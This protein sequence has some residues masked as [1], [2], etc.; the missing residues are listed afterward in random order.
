MKDSFIAKIL[1]EDLTEYFTN[2]LEEIRIRKNKPVIFL[3]PEREIIT[4]KIFYRND[5][6]EFLEKITQSS[7]YSYYDDIANGFITV[8]GGHRVGLCGDAVYENEKLKSLRDITGI[9]IRIAKEMKGIGEGVFSKITSNKSIGNTL[10]IAPPGIGKTT[11][12]RDIT[13]LI[14]DNIEKT[15]LA[16]IDERNEISA[17]FMGNT[18]ND[19]GLRTDVFCGY[20]KYDGIMRALRSMSPNVIVVDEIGSKEDV[21]AIKK[22]FYSGVKIIASVH[23]ENIDDVFGNL[24]S[25]IKENV[26]DFFVTLKKDGT[27]ERK[28]IIDSSTDV[29][30]K[31]GRE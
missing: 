7:I 26:F 5:I 27:Y 1:P 14:S 24:S 11:L 23:G 4:K 2:T 19:V 25:L 3:Y 21:E 28:C 10:V 13:R 15:R 31:K 12:L 9:N 17:S 30:R 20:K 18:Q 6:N 22:C 16:L 8:T 29:F